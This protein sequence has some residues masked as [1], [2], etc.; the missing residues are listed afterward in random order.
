MLAVSF[1]EGI[2]GSFGLDVSGRSAHL[3]VQPMIP[4][5]NQIG[6]LD[7]ANSSIRNPLRKVSSDSCNGF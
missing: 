6:H 2:W 5:P 7:D 1:R 4:W 3:Q